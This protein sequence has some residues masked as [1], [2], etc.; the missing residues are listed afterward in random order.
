MPKKSDYDLIPQAS[1]D[2]HFVNGFQ[3]RM[4]NLKRSAGAQI[5][6][7]FESLDEA[8]KVGLFCKLQFIFNFFRSI[9]ELY[10]ETILLP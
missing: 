6:T 9:K 7:D 5:K 8:P 3:G 2:Y 10:L 4:L 1:N